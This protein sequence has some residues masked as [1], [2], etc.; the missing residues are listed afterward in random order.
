MSRFD[1][2]CS[3]IAFWIM[4]EYT[5]VRCTRTGDGREDELSKKNE[6]NGYLDREGFCECQ[7]S[8]GTTTG[9]EDDF[10]YWDVCLKCGKRIED[11]H[12]YYNHY[13][14]ENHDDI[15]I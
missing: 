2:G 3:A 8:P 7:G 13:D 1:S 9:F 6:K 5:W 14:G 12:H 11:G 15:D 10:G 4:P